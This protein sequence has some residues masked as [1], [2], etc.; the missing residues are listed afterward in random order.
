M[1]TGPGRPLRATR[2]ASTT[3]SPRSSGSITSQFFL[4][5]GAVIRV[6]GASWNACLPMPGRATWPVMATSGIESIIAS[7]SGVT[8]LQAPGP[9]V[10]KQTPGRPVTCA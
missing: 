6:T 10:A 4:V 5:I 8:R 3:T 1:R 2:K 9:E 7:A